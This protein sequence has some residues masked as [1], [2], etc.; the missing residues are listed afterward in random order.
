MKMKRNNHCSQLKLKENINR[1][2]E[3][4][5]QLKS[6]YPRLE[7][8][9]KQQQVV[10]ATRRQFELPLLLKKRMKKKRRRLKRLSNMSPELVRQHH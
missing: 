7:K 5:P 3:Q 10:A 9:Q 8:M 4:V 6:V 2:F 1:E